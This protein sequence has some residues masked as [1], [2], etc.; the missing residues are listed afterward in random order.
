VLF[1][2]RIAET[3]S[4]RFDETGFLNS[5]MAAIEKEIKDSGAHTT[6]E[7]SS[8]S[9]SFSLSI[10]GDTHGHIEIS[11]K[12]VGDQYYNVAASIDEKYGVP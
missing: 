2:C 8:N 4:D 12:S 3:E 9:S 6:Q 11:G 7:G 10:G 1:T 5:L